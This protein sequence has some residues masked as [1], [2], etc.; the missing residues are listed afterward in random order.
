MTTTN[1]RVSAD[2]FGATR[3]ERQLRELRGRLRRMKLRG[4]DLV[5]LEEQIAS[6][7]NAIGCEMMAD[8]FACVD[9]DDAEVD[10]NGTCH[11]RIDRHR[12]TIHTMFGGVEIQRT[13]YRKDRKSPTV[14]AFDKALG[15]VESFYTPKIARV[16]SLLQALLVREDA[17]ALLRE[18]GGIAV[19]AA[20]QHRLPQAIMARYETKRDEIER[21]VREQ[22][23][24]P[25][26]AV[27]MQVGLDGVMVPQDGEHAKPRGREP[28]GEPAPARHERSY[29]AVLVPGPAATD[30]TVGRAWHEAS[31]GTVAFF[32]A[33]GEHVQTTYVGRMPEEHKS[34]LGQM[35]QR[36]AMHALA[37]RPDLRVVMASD[38]ALGHW[39]TLAK[40]RAEMPEHSRNSSFDL[41]DFFHVSEH[42]QKACD[43]IEGTGTADARMRRMSWCETLKEYDNGVDRVLQSLRHQR[44]TATGR[45]THETIEQVIEYLTTH[46]T[47]MK[48]KAASDAKLPIA[49]GPTEAAAKSLVGVPMKRSGARFSQHG[50]QTVLTLLASHKSGRFESLFDTIVETYAARVTQVKSAA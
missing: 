33:D 6:G 28:E 7:L 47:R 32:D 9:I 27:A 8:V 40:I 15:I 21:R 50:G 4:I 17:A 10:I 34:T 48:Y 42:L 41:L 46:R 43:A 44:R 29:G 39:T 11:S 16:V 45:K 13:T 19:S 36:E 14:S 18:V 3:A 31:V 37:Q 25:A 2:E 24:I 35:L 38:G 30:S 49:T 22:Q 20:T 1:D 12:A 23:M 5:A 26:D